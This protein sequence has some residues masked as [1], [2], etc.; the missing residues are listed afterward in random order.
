MSCIVYCFF[1]SI[2]I[3]CIEK[4]KDN[5][6]LKFYNYYVLWEGE[7][8]VNRYLLWKILIVFYVKI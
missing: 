5:I 3:L 1:C 6:S 8:C 7:G 2:E 4:F